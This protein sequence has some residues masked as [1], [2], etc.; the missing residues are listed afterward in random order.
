V[1]AAYDALCHPLRIW[2]EWVDVKAP[3]GEANLNLTQGA[4]T[5]RA[6]TALVR[7]ALAVLLLREPLESLLPDLEL[8]A[9]DRTSA[10][11]PLADERE[12]ADQP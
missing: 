4:R 8:D 5:H 1:R 9:I 12:P 3:H 6:G 11:D 10:P 2:D 7:E